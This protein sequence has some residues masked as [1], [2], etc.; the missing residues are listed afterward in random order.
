MLAFACGSI[1]PLVPL[2]LQWLHVKVY[3]VAQHVIKGLMCWIVLVHM[4]VSAPHLF[5]V[6]L[7][8]LS[9]SVY[10]NFRL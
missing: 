4:V 6:L 2:W 10:T 7:S 8:L 1:E 9:V 5:E 3:S